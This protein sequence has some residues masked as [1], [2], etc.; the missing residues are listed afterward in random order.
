MQTTHIYIS[1]THTHTH[2]LTNTYTDTDTDTHTT[3]YKTWR[4]LV[5]GDVLAHAAATVG[6]SAAATALATTYLRLN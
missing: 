6:A 2:T 5:G 4:S 3:I 1:N